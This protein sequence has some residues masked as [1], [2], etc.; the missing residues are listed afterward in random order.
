VL[1]SFLLKINR[2]G[3]LVMKLDYRKY[4]LILIILSLL[5]MLGIPSVRANSGPPSNVEITVINY[6]VEFSLDLL[7]Y[8][9]TTLTQEEIDR[10]EALIL[11]GE[12]PF[13]DTFFPVEYASYQDSEGYVSNSLYGSADFFYTYENDNTNEYF[14]RLLMDIPRE[15]KILL[16]TESGVIITSELI[17]MTQFDYRLTFD[18]EGIDMTLDQSNVGI[19]SGNVGNPW[20]NVTTWVNFLL[21]LILTLAI[22]LGILFLFGFRK[23]STFIIILGM[24]IISQIALNVALISNFYVI[25]SSGYQFVYTFIIGE[26][27]V[28]TIEAIL[29]SVFIKEH[30]LFS[31]ISY[32][33]IANAASLI[34]GL[35]VASWLSFLI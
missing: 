29:V 18:L 22:E 34:I 31:K 10:A 26:L 35:L 7:I 11:E 3:V 16:Y 15:F 4:V 1:N 13:Q 25:D 32:S 12:F 17:T 27:L 28:F 24:N 23:K 20:M 19:I 5:L 33:F 9:N 30:K 21:R 2:K 8:Q 6:D 14:A